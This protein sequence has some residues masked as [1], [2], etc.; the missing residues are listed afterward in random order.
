MSILSKYGDDEVKK[1]QEFLRKTKD[2]HEKDRARAIIK[3]IQGRKRSDGVLLLWDGAPWHRGEV[4]KYLKHETAKK[5]R[6]E[7]TYFP[8]YSPDFNPQ[9]H[10]WKEAKEKTTKSCFPRAYARW[11]NILWNCQ[12]N[13]NGL[14]FHITLL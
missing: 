4:K 9:E 8:P 12:K 5:W 7:I 6:L 2:P 14:I 10:V 11:Y 13:S 1:L 3:R